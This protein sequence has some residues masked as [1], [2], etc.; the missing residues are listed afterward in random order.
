M[1]RS[2]ETDQRAIGYGVRFVLTILRL[3]ALIPAA[4]GLYSQVGTNS[5]WIFRTTK[6]DDQSF[7]QAKR[8]TRSSL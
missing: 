6:L 7:Q 3:A 1:L 8:I 5:D 2:R 4:E